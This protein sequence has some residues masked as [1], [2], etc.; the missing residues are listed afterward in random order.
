MFLRRKKYPSG[1]TGII[2]AEKVR[3]RMR[4]LCTIGISDDPAELEGLL[5]K[6][7]LWMDKEDAR[8]HPRLDLFG[9]DHKACVLR[10][11]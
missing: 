3:G 4:E 8:R 5:A 11:F 2:V 10:L 9:E 7:R 1:R 6:G